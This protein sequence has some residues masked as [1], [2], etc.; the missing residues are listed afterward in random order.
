M[1]FGMCETPFR[2]DGLLSREV[3]GL[4]VF[5]DLREPP[6]LYRDNG[7]I[8]IRSRES[9]AISSPD[10]KTPTSTSDCC[11][12]LLSGSRLPAIFGELRGNQS[13]GRFRADRMALAG[14]WIRS[15]FRIFRRSLVNRGEIDFRFCGGAAAMVS[16]VVT[17]TAAGMAMDTH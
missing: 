1:D 2:N 4:A 5:G 3:V 15:S 8:T 10:V 9:A 13:F 17:F 7:R 16:A 14:Q 12:W 11:V 6:V